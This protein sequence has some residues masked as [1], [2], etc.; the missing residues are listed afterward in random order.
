MQK[1]YIVL[2]D[3][4]ETASPVLGVYATRR[5]AIQRANAYTHNQNREYSE[6]RADYQSLSPYAFYAK[7][8][9]IDWIPFAYVE[10]RTVAN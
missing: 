5:Q 3:E 1:V 6:V 7:Y 2:N 8:K 4:G 10:T 9:P